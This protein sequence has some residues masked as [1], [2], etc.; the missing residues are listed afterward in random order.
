MSPLHLEILM[1]YYTRGGDHEQ[2]KDNDTT[3]NFAY[4]LAE[5]GWLY[6]PRNAT[7]TFKITTEGKLV[8]EKIIAVLTREFGE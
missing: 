4:Q 5:R 7:V 1:F 3:D 6:T 2:V 8:A